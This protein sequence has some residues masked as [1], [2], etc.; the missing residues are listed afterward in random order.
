MKCCCD[1][2]AA[3]TDYQCCCDDGAA[4]TDYQCCFDDGAAETDD[5]RLCDD[6]FDLDLPFNRRSLSA[7]LPSPQLAQRDSLLSFAVLVA[8]WANMAIP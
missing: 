3:D 8:V 6:T 1:D 5:A 4:D 7:T 2:G